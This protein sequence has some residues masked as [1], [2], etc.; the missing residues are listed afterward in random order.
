VDLS[1]VFEDFSTNTLDMSP[2][3]TFQLLE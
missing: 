3:F 2:G 1:I